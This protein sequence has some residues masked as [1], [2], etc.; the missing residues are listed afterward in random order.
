MEA[1]LLDRHRQVGRKSVDRT[2]VDELAHERP[3]RQLEPASRR[4]LG[5]C[6]AAG[7]HEHIRLELE[8]VRLLAHLHPTCSRTPNELARDARRIGDSVLAADDGAEDVVGPQSGDE[9]GIDPLDRH[10]ERPL[11]RSPLLELGQTLLAR[12]EEE[13]ADLLEERRSELREEPDARLRQSHLGL[14]RELLADAAHRL[15]RRAA[16][17]R[18]R[19][20]EHHAVGARERQ[21]IGD[22]GADRARAGYDDSSQPSSSVRSPSVRPRRGA[23]TSSR[24]GTPRAPRTHF[25]AACRGNRSIAARSSPSAAAAPVEGSRTAAATRSGNAEPRAETAPTAPAA[26]PS[27]ISASGPTKTSSPSTR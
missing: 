3:D 22:R 24:I 2:D 25:R 14:G 13:V 27:A 18:A 8:R 7:D 10:A 6:R 9:R 23:R 17:D 15:P 26:S 19:V 16:G 11:D 12:R 5:G 20:G 4:D 1:V 21:V